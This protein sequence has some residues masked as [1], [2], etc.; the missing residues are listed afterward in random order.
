MIRNKTIKFNMDDPVKRKLWE[1]LERLPHGTFSEE[2]LAYWME[3]MKE[4]EG[5]R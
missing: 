4:K 3:K 5:Q 2:T 1:Y